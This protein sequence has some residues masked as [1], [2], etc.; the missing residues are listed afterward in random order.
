MRGRLPC[1]RRAIWL[2]IGLVFLVYALWELVVLS[3]VPLDQLTQ[4]LQRGQ[5]AVSPLQ[6][7]LGTP[8]LV[9]AGQ[10]FGLFAIVTSYLGVSLGLTDFLLDGWKLNRLTMGLL[11]QLPPFLITLIS[12]HL[13]LTALDL[14]GGIGSALLLGLL[15]ILLAWRTGRRK[16]LW[17]LLA[18]VLLDLGIE[19][20][21]VLA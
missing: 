18:L 12:P 10:F 21:H 11:V 15:P 17:P 16:L 13:F 2:G 20:F 8:W 1:L 7:Q 19:A 9:Q 4:A 14:G 6:Q 3:A 5:S